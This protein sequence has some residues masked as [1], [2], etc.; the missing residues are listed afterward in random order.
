MLG[1]AVVAYGFLRSSAVEREASRW[2]RD[3]HETR[4]RSDARW[5]DWPLSYA[6]QQVL[7]RRF[8]RPES[9]VAPLWDGARR[10]LPERIRA[11]VPRYPGARERAIVLGP[12]LI[13]IPKMPAV[14]QSLLEAAL[15]PRGANRRFAVQFAC[16]DWPVPVS[17]LPLLETLATDADPVIRSEVARALLGI[18]PGNAAVE[19]VLA[20]LQSDQVAVVREAA[21]SGYRSDATGERVPWPAD[22]APETK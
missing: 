21:R 1:V 13:E 4:M 14:R 16:M 15:D 7:I 3:F 22:D 5:P 9:P 2:V 11:V 12:V 18:P 6:G 19:R 20:Q 17:L 8:T 10:L